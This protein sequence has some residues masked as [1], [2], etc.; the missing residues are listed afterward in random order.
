MFKRPVADMNR[1]GISEGALSAGCVVHV[2]FYKIVNGGKIDAAVLNKRQHHRAKGKTADEMRGAVYRV[3]EPKTVRIASPAVLFA[4][5]LRAGVYLLELAGKV[6]FDRKVERSYDRMRR[7][8]FHA[9]RHVAP[10]REKHLAGAT[11]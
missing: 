11:D 3:T 6:A 5:K 10:V 1:L 9:L 4:R 7:A 2:V 8:V